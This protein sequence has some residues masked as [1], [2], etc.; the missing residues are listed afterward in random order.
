MKNCEIEILFDDHFE[1]N[2]NDDHFE[3]D[4]NGDK[5]SDWDE[6]FFDPLKDIKDVAFQIYLSSGKLNDFEFNNEKLI[7]LL[8]DIYDI[9]R[10]FLGKVS[11][12]NIPQAIY[13]LHSKAFDLGLEYIPSILRELYSYYEDNEFNKK[14]KFFY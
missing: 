8:V 7:S 13:K 3:K 5:K 14:E 4:F 6:L 2:F 9:S 11:I 10:N 1:K 12:E